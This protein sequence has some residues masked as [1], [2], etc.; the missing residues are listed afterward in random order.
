LF[1]T[2]RDA[3]FLTELAG[4]VA[5]RTLK[6]KPSQGELFCSKALPD[7]CIVERLLPNINALKSGCGPEKRSSTF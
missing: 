2:V 1:I 4:R 7:V 5:S 3:A 6:S